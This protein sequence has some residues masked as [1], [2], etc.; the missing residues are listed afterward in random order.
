MKEK[1][2]MRILKKILTEVAVISKIA[3]W[4]GGGVNSWLGLYEPDVPKEVTEFWD[5]NKKK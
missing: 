4:G 2:K 3:A 5:C 1:N